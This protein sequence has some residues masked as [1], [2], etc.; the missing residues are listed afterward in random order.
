MIV[1]IPSSKDRRGLDIYKDRLLD[2]KLLPLSYDREIKDLINILYK[3]MCGYY[4]LNIFDYV[5]FVSHNRT[6]NCVNHSLMKV[7]LCKTTT[8][9]SSLR[10]L[11]VSFSF[12]TVCVE[13]LNL[14]I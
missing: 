3:A 8:V 7:P 5:S 4:D 10:T 6:R 9:H 14:Q 12:G 1:R 11:I 13:M 2:L